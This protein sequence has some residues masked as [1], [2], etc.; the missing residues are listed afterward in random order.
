MDAPKINELRILHR[1]LA[2]YLEKQHEVLNNCIVA[3]AAIRGALAT[4]PALQEAYKASLEEV[5]VGIFLVDQGYENTH[6][7]ILKKLKDW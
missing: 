2:A 3:V 4:D 5:K 6:Q 1:D 7:T